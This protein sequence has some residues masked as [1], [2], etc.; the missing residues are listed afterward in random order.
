MFNNGDTFRCGF[1]AV[2]QATIGQATIADAAIDKIWKLDPC[3]RFRASRI[4]R[5]SLSGIGVVLLAAT[6]IS[7]ANV[8]APLVYQSGTNVYTLLV[9]RFVLFLALGGLWIRLQTSN[10]RIV[11]ADRLSCYGA[12][13]AYI[14]GSGALLGSFAYLP[15]S[16]AI[17]VFYTFPFI[18]LVLE[19]LLDRRLP[20]PIRLGCV[21]VAFVGVTLALGANAE[22]LNL[23]GLGLAIIAAVGVASA[24]T[25]TGRALKHID[26]LVMTFHMSVSGL[27]FVVVITAVSNNFSIGMQT[28]LSVVLLFVAVVSFAVAFLAM[29]LGVR[30]IGASQA[31]MFMNLEPVFTI[32][33]AFFVLQE[34]LSPAQL[35]GAALVLTSVLA[36]QRFGQTQGS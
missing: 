13:L 2:L 28:T 5:F 33:L 15:V 19:S 32:I 18:T 17:L 22:N 34:T 20:D 24:F 35:L 21:A 23:L 9:L 7:L 16:L 36:A 11:I 14:V 25:W 6:C 26:P 8:L 4:K 30:L 3:T 1:A 10:A 29:F 27:V 12:G 31:A